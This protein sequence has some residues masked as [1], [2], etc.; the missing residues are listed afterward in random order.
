MI[1]ASDTVSVVIRQ[2]IVQLRT[3][4][5]MRGRVYSVNSVATIMSN[6]LGDFRAGAMAALL[7]LI[8]S[9][10]AGGVSHPRDRPDFDQD[11]QRFLRN[12][13]LRGLQA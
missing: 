8:P 13:P 5:E 2:T 4:D 7:G 10:L 3:P 12:R 9:V 11:F 6:Q 1:G